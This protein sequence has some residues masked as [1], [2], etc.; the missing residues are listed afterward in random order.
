MATSADTS[1]LVAVEEFP[2][3]VTTGAAYLD[4]GA[5]SQTPRV[6][7]DAMARYYETAR[8]S[9]HRERRRRSSSSPT[10]R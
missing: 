1:P 6:V 2:T 10:S 4:S 7:L 9:V 5:T 8:A 3:L